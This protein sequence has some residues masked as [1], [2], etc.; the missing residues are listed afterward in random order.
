MMWL[1]LSIA[2]SYFLIIRDPSAF[3]ERLEGTASTDELLNAAL[4]PFTGVVVAIGVCILVATAALA[5]AYPLTTHNSPADYLHA[6]RLVR[7]WRMWWDRW[8]MSHAYRAERWSWT[9]R[10]QVLDRLH[11]WG[12][13]WQ[14]WEIVRLRANIV[15]FILLFALFT[16]LASQII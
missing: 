5:A 15:L 8:Q 13:F 4:S 7:Y 11:G 12:T 1:G 10:T 6:N 16:V 9:V 3:T 2:I 14:R